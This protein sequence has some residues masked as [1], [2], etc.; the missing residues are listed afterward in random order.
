MADTSS[1]SQASTIKADNSYTHRGY[2][3]GRSDGRGSYGQHYNVASSQAQNANNMAFLAQGMAAMNFQDASYTTSGRTN[4]VS[5]TSGPYGGYNLNN[6]IPAAFWPGANQLVMGGHQAFNNGTPHSASMYAQG[7]YMTHGYGRTHDNSPMSQGWTPT[8][9]NGDMPSLITPRRESMSSAEND[10]PGTPNYSS[11][12]PMTHGGVTILNRS[13]SGTYTTSTP[14]PLQMMFP[15]GM[16]LGKVAEVDTISPRLKILVTKEPAIPPAI[17][18][19]SSP[20]KPLDRA[21]ENPRGET[22]VYIRGLMPETSDDMLENWGRRFGDIKSSKS[23][24]DHTTGQCKGFGFVR[25]HNYKDAE[26]CIR[27]FHHLGYEVSF[28]RESFYSK[29]KAIAD[30]HNTNLYVSNLPKTMNEH[31]LANIFAPHKVCSARIL[32][33][34]NGTGRG[35]GFARFEIRTD[36]E[37]IIRQFNNKVIQHNGE[38]HTIQIRYADTQE[39]KHLKQTTAA[40]RQFRSAE[41]EYATQVHRSGWRPMGSPEAA[42]PTGNDFENYMS[43]HARFLAA[44]GFS[45]PAWRPYSQR[46]PLSVMSPNSTNIRRNG[47]VSIN[48]T[49]LAKVTT[50]DSHDGGVALGGESAT[51]AIAHGDNSPSRVRFADK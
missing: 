49:P 44:K 23:I 35:V 18:A 41:Y 15:G 47:S 22:N 24:I 7:A 37:E 1:V 40:A 11:Y 10:T 45:E 16:P 17:P 4:S 19:P 6:A 50:H 34:S 2:A 36:C 51:P 48:S 31:E 27:G 28:A 39:Q 8:Q 12:N 13:P 43:Q 9:M 38:D 29:L 46:T 32:R 14:S 20:L 30:D 25:Y 26:D 5:A 3:N 42:A 21:L 33:N